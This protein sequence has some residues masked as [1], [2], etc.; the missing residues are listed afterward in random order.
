MVGV[1]FDAMLWQGL[2]VILLIVTIEV[3]DQQENIRW[4]KVLLE[5]AVVV[6]GTI[7][8]MG[9][10]VFVEK[11]FFKPSLFYLRPT[12]TLGDGP[13]TELFYRIL[14]FLGVELG[15]GTGTSAP[16]GFALR[17]TI[18]FLLITMYRNRFLKHNSLKS[19]TISGLNI[20]FLLL[21]LL[22]RLLIGAHTVSDLGLGTGIGI[23]SFWLA[24]S[25]IEVVKGRL[26]YL[27]ELAVPGLTYFLT[28]LF[29]CHNPT[30]WLLLGAITSAIVLLTYL[31]AS[32][33][34]SL[35]KN[36]SSGFST[37]SRRHLS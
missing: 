24:F 20:T 5:S 4:I 11:V 22:S 13:V 37:F 28:V 14:Q 29:F 25:L 31:S 12:I 10:E 35:R 16:S 19:N 6:L 23:L 8:I 7:A 18:I 9:L 27:E 34:Q 17:Q 32:Y 21:V 2:S 15:K 36:C 26:E 33:Y 1:L 3:R 30:H